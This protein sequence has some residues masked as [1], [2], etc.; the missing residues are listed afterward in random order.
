MQYFRSRHILTSSDSGLA[1][2]NFKGKN[3]GKGKGNG[4]NFKGMKG[5]GKGKNSN[6]GTGKGIVCYTCGT[7]GHTSR[8]CSFN[9]V[10]AVDDSSW[11]DTS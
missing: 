2:G 3:K 9:R 7:P 8:E 10:N 1:P 6:K 5:K 11:T 4:K